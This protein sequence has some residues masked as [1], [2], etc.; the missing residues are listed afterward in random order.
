MDSEIVI[1]VL[2]ILAICLIP[3]CMM[4]VRSL[5]K[6]RKALGFLYKLAKEFNESVFQTGNWNSSAIGLT[7]NG[8]HIFVVRESKKEFKSQTINLSLF[9]NCRIINDNS[10]SPY[11]EGNFKVTDKVELELTGANKAT[12]RICFYNRE[13]DGD[14][15]TD[16]LQIAETWRRKINEYIVKKG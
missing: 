5:S 10:N 8:S 4:K 2:I 13:E 7:K 6:K 11:K 12:E 14:L 15:L 9:N 1:P 16:E 3:I